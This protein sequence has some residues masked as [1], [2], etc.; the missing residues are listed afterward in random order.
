[1]NSPG[2]PSRL[3]PH[4]VILVRPA[5][6]RDVYGSVNYEYGESAMR[7]PIRAWLQQ[8]QRAEVTEDGRR[9]QEQRW[10]MITDY[11]DVRALDHVER[12]GHTFETDGPPAPTL[13][14]FQG[15]HHIESQLRLVTG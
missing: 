14:P 8:D 5:E 3:L 13:S 15:L 1:M 6:H 11:D 7:T 9:A 2:I 12:Q 4:T 10:L